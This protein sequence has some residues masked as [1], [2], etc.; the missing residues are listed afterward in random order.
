MGV[1]ELFW[2]DKIHGDMCSPYSDIFVPN[3]KEILTIFCTKQVCVRDPIRVLGIWV[4]NILSPKDLDECTSALFNHVVKNIQFV[5]RGSTDEKKPLC[6]CNPRTT[7][8]LEEAKAVGT[9]ASAITD[10][11]TGTKTFGCTK[12]F[13]ANVCKFSVVPKDGNGRYKFNLY[14]RSH[15]AKTNDSVLANLSHHL[16]DIAANCLEELAP[17][18]FDN[19]REHAE[20]AKECQLGNDTG[21]FAGVTLVSDY[22]AHPHKDFNDFPKGVIGLFS[23]TNAS[24][25]AQA[26]MHILVNYSLKLGGNP[27]VAFDLGNNSLF[28]EAA[29]HETHASS[30]FER[31]AGR[32]PSRVA[33]VFNRHD[34]LQHPD[35]GSQVPKPPPKTPKTKRVSK[36]LV[37]PI[38]K[39]KC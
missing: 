33:L 27:G 19:M 16:A 5:P 8:T 10:K 7:R 15:G 13:S 34:V 2:T 6:N 28:L 24:I 4:R 21:V 12:K 26:Q 35:H 36:P 14:Q 17:E 38:S 22:V 11:F 23:F 25:A 29:M 30:R 37:I 31:P 39:K 3:E 32:D 1:H 18:A 20:K 9:K